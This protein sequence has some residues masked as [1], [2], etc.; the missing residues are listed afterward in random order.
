MTDIVNLFKEFS[1][2]IIREA[3]L[4]QIYDVAFDPTRSWFVPRIPRTSEGVRGMEVNIPF[5]TKLPWSWRNMSELGYTPTGNKL[6]S[7]RQ[8][9]ELGCAAASAVVSFKQLKGCR[10]EVSQM[11][12]LLDMQMDA[13]RR[14]FPYFLRALVWSSQSSGKAIGKAAS[15]SGTTI[16]LDNAGL[17]NTALKDRAKL[18]E[19]GMVLQ[20]YRGDVKLGTPVEVFAVGKGDGTVTLSADPGIAD[21]DVCV[22]SDIGGLD[23]PGMENFPGLLDVIDDD[24]VFQG[25]DRSDSSYA[26]ARGR[27]VD[28]TG[29]QFGYKPISTFLDT[30][31]NPPKAFAHKDLVR[32]Y[33]EQNFRSDIRYTQGGTFEDGFE[34]VKV[35]NTT[36]YADWDT[37]R[38]KLIV[39]DFESL[40]IYETGAMEI[41]P[42]GGTNGW[43]QVAGRTLLECPVGWW[44][45]LGATDVRK[46][47][48]MTNIDLTPAA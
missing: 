39:A 42:G 28:A 46:M 35:D 7:A 16:T 13:L 24:N 32:A 17:W 12:N 33:W 38:D 43:R 1:G 5:L 47:G 27:V 19:P 6:D 45:T 3:W 21:N 37:D 2:P 30:V 10:M 22:P 29:V 11:Q 18:F 4:P 31:Y 20:W 9:F 8:K 48:V 15:V 40:K 36:I 14:Q 41:L 25:V 34:T 23:S 26:W 44:G